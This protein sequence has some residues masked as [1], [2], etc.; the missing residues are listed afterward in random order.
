VLITFIHTLVAA[1]GVFA[2][3]KVAFGSAS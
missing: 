2:V 1:A 3:A